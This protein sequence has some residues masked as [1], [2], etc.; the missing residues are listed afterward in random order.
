MGN[1][2]R[3]SIITV[4][5]NAGKTIEQAIRS[6]VC[7]TYDNI[8]YIIIDGMSTDNTVDIIKKYKDEL[9]LL[10]E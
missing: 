10:G 2:Y 9:F 1:K 7:Q 5:Y 8:E 3:I 4:S 6:V